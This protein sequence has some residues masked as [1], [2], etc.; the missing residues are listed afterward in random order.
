M[1]KVHKLVG[2]HGKASAAEQVTTRRPH[3]VVEAAAAAMLDVRMGEVPTFTYSGWCHAGLPHRRI[4]DDQDW[5]IET[6]Y[7]TLVVEPGKIRQQGSGQ[8]EKSYQYF[9]VPFGP[10]SRLIL[11]YLMDRALVTEDRNVELGQT[12]ANF[13]TRLELAPGG[14]TRN[15]I[16]NQIERISRCKLTFHIHGDGFRGVSNQSIVE[17]A[18]LFDDDR[19]YDERQPCLFTDRIRLSEGFYQQLR[20]HAV[21]LD[22]RAIRKIHNNSRALDVYSWMAFRLHHIQEPTFV[23]WK[24]LMPQFGAGIKVARNFP[25]VMRDDAMLALSVYEKAKVEIQER[26]LLLCPSPPP[27]SMA[28]RLV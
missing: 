17:T 26:G 7:V 18:M 9:G 22:E 11:Y 20:R 28:P 4:P 5:E 23:P 27:V 24:A 12:L 3:R 25:S 13:L 1:G 14:E 2:E 21:R 16:R 8:Y 19:G 6:D 15:R 10:Y